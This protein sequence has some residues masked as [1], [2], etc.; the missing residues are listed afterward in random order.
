MQ[1]TSTLL[2]GGQSPDVVYKALTDKGVTEFNATKIIGDWIVQNSGFG[3]RSFSFTNPVTP[4][5][6]PDCTPRFVR[7]FV[8]E[9]WVDGVSVVQAGLT[10][11]EPGFNDRLHK[12]ENDLDS[13]SDDVKRLFGCVGDLR[14]SVAQALTEAANELN[15]IDQD[16]G[17]LRGP[18]RAGSGIGGSFL[19]GAAVAQFVGTT[20][21]FDQPVNVWQTEQG[22]VTLPAVEP[23]D[24]TGSPQVTSTANF[25]KFVQGNADVAAAFAANPVSVQNVIDRFGSEAIDASGTTVQQ[26]L[27]VL[28][29]TTQFQNVDQLTSALAASN[30][31]VIRATGIGD[32]TIAT[33]FTNLGS[34]IQAVSAAPVDRLQ[35]LPAGAAAALSTAGITTVGALAAASPTDVN[36]ALTKAGIATSVVDAA[37]FTGIARTL[38]SLR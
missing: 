18:V 6:S 28:P 4:T 20:K 16:L 11:G 26:A 2:L 29:P 21:Y 31:A 34:G 10:P 24:P 7:S 14:A 23:P 33:S 38:T 35:A 12:I 15:Q 17:R 5:E 19:G 27:S 36:E 3:T 1:V 8:H 9:D 30:A 37:G 22:M 32:A 25:S 13:L